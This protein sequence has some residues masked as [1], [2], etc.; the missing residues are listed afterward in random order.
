MTPSYLL[1]TRPFALDIKTSHSD[2]V[3]SLARARTGGLMGH[4]STRLRDV[5]RTQRYQASQDY[6]DAHLR[7]ADA[8]RVR[9]LSRPSVRG[10]ALARYCL[11]LTIG[12]GTLLE[13]RAEAQRNHDKL[14]RALICEPRGH[15]EMYGAVLVSKTELQKAAVGTFFLTNDGSVLPLP[16]QP[17]RSRLTPATATAQC[18]DMLPSQSLGW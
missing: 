16:G 9:W 10:N 7:R 15:R 1:H 8:N 5:D 13:R 4:G 3:S 17:I 11:R 12:R 6:R 2:C 14:R 18:A